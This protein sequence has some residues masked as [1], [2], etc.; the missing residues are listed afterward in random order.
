MSILSDCH[1]KENKSKIYNFINLKDLIEPINYIISKNKSIQ[2]IIFNDLN[3]K[4]NLLKLIKFFNR[5]YN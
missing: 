2:K 5:T 4:Y 1:F 3:F